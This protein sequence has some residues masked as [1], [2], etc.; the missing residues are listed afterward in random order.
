MVDILTRVHA[1]S[2]VKWA[3][4]KPEVIVLSGDL[5]KNTEA[6]LFRDHYSKRF[7][8]MGLAEQ[9]M[10][11]VAG[12]LAREGMIPFIYTFSVF[13]YRRALDQLQMSIAYPNLKVRLLGFLPGL[14]TPGGVTHQAIDEIAITTS[15]PNMNVISVGDATEVETLLEAI[16]DIDG[17]VYVSMM[18]GRVPRLFPKNEPLKFRKARILSRGHDVTILSSGFATQDAIYAIDVMKKKGVSIEHLHVSTLKPFDDAEILKSIAKAKLGVISYENHLAKGGLG[19]AVAE[20]IA[21]NAL[22]VKLRRIG[23]QDTYAHGGS[24]AYL[25]KVYHI[26]AMTLVKEVEHLCKQKLN[27]TSDDIAKAVIEVE[28]GT[29]KPEAL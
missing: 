8:T 12:G 2:M 4:D 23:L 22:A 5:T 6:D 25:K 7:F 9:N 28:H 27:I 19:S 3:K 15:I 13:M 21:E 10:L 29:H 20:M 17:P 16:E 26:D 11:G 24:H 1:K 14:S 18:R